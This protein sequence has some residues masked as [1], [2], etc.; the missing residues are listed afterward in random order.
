MAVVDVVVVITSTSRALVVLS[1]LW[2]THVQHPPSRHTMPH[3]R[4]SSTGTETS[5]VVLVVVVAG[6][7]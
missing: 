2:L 7:W 3:P 5:V 4:L 1:L 6:H